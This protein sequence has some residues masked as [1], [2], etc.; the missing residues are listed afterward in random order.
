MKRWVHIEKADEEPDRC[1]RARHFGRYRDPHHHRSRLE[2]ENKANI[3]LARCPSR[4]VEMAWKQHRAQAC[5]RTQ[6]V[7]L[8]PV[9]FP[10]E[11]TVDLHQTLLG[12]SA[13]ERE[14][15]SASICCSS[16]PS[17]LAVVRR[18]LIPTSILGF[19]EVSLVD[20]PNK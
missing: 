10:L 8:G 14:S 19:R 18:A 17:L 16:S 3:R 11:L 1:A 15:S 7:C 5:Y 6:N 12:C 9:S 2:N 13:G 4:N 20:A